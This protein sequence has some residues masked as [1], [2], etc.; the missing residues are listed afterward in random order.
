MHQKLHAFIITFFI[1]LIP[2]IATA[3]GPSSTDRAPLSGKE[4]TEQQRKDRLHEVATDRNAREEIRNAK[5]A[6]EK[7]KAK[8]TK[9]TPVKG[10][11]IIHKNPKPDSKE[12]ITN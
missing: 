9:Q 12:Q 2:C 11:I 10:E 6:E 1:L 4:Q 7:A 5:I 8:R 3:F